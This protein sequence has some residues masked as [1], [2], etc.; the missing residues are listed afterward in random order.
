MYWKYAASIVV[1]ATGLF[2]A[3]ASFAQQLGS[4]P[5]PTMA[6][7]PFFAPG[8]PPPP[9]FAAPEAGNTLPAGPSPKEVCMNVVALRA[10][11]LGYLKAK[12]DL[13]PPQLAAWQEAEAVFND[14]AKGEREACS[15]LPAEMAQATVL[16]A[17]TF[18]EER[19][20]SHQLQLQKVGPAIR[21]LYESLSASQRKVMDSIPPPLMF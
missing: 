14:V 10:G 16:R 19:T 4:Y 13:A 21:K 17:I 2:G 11:F 6:G 8:L 3:G 1:A 7:L 18:A 9:P 15:R 5:M 12:L 20:A